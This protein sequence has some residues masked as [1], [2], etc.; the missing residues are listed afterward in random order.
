MEIVHGEQRR[1]SADERHRAAA[2]VCDVGATQLGREPA[3]F[4]ADPQRTVVAVGRCLDDHEPA[5]ELG[6][7]ADERR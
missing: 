2:V 6:M 4:E 1:A 7:G 5:R 3:V